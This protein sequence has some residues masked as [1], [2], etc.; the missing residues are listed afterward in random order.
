[1]LIAS[2]RATP[3]TVGD[4]L[5]S[6]AGASVDVIA[7][8]ATLWNRMYAKPWSRRFVDLEASARRRYPTVFNIPKFLGD[9]P[10]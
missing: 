1:M 3:E 2:A 10:R 6:L 9:V 5:E 4:Y 7:R 8:M